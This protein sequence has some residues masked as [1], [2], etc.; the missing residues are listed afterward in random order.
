[1]RKNP[2]RET[3][4]KEERIRKKKELERAF[5]SSIAVGC[6]GAKLLY[7][8]NGL[9]LNRMAV[10][11]P[12]KF[13]KAVKRNREKRIAREIFRKTKHLLRPGHDIIFI[14]YPG[15]YDHGERK[16]QFFTL[17]RKAKLLSGVYK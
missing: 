5:T 4:R 7:R 1:M 2:I 8:E 16:E 13:G 15:E 17:Y 3:F 6:K 10:I 11:L 9:K 12:K 14:L